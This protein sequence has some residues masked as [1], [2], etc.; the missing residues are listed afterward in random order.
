MTKFLVAWFEGLMELLLW[1]LLLF[2]ILLG[3]SSA[4]TEML[5][6]DAAIGFGIASVVSALFLG[7]VLVLVEIKKNLGRI[8]EILKFRATTGSSNSIG[9]TD[10][11]LGDMDS[12]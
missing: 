6:L 10:P 11:S 12:A 8:E 1:I 4:P 9:R 5:A 2:G 7:P 3:I